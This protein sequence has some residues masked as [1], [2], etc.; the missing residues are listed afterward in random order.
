MGGHISRKRILHI[1]RQ[2]ASVFDPDR[3]LLF[4]SHARGRPGPDSDVD[5][6]VVMRTRD[7][8]AQAIAIGAVLNHDFPLDIVV[9]TPENLVKRLALG[10]WFL[11]EAIADG[12]V[13]HAK[14]DRRVGAKGGGRYHRRAPVARRKTTA[15]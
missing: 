12:E 4:G 2:I 15:V 5:L 7:E 9:R 10:D 1:A 13:L 11:R 6:L 8:T 14:A 3:I